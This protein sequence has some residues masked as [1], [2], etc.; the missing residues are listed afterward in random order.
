M[1]VLSGENGRVSFS[2]PQ[3]NDIFSSNEV[4]GVSLEKLSSLY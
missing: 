1:S 2:V 3:T 4:C